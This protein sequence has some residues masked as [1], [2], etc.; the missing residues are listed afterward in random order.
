M[1]EI[2]NEMRPETVF[3]LFPA[4]LTCLTAPFLFYRCCILCGSSTSQTSGCQCKSKTNSFDGGVN[5]L[6]DAAAVISDCVQTFDD[7]VVIVQNFQI[8]SYIDTA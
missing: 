6:A 1:G 2:I 4:S 7:V 8:W 3:T 5:A